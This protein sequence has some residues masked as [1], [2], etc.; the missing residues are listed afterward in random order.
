[1]RKNSRQREAIR[2]ALMNCT[3]HPSAEDVY[4]MLK[5]SYPNIS[6]GTVYR[7]LNLLT[8]MGEIMKVP[9]TIGSDR[10]DGN[11]SNHVHFFCKNCDAII[12][13]HEVNEDPL[14]DNQ[15][16]NCFNGKIEGHITSYYGIC[17]ECLSSTNQAL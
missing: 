9:G 5:G 6:L 14:I 2:T 7:N 3:S 4:Q 1:M 8:E 16:Q 11:T 10:F 17:P 12:D 13:L 15:A